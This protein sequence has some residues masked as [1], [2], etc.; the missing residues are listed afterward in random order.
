MTAT[1][2]VLGLQIDLEGDNAHP[3]RCTQCSTCYRRHREAARCC[4]AASEDLRSGTVRDFDAAWEA[5]QVA[6]Y[7]AEMDAHYAE[8]HYNC[9]CGECFTEIE[10][11]RQ[12]RKC[13]TYAEH[14]FCAEVT[15][16]DQDDKEVWVSRR[17]EGIRQQAAGQVFKDI[18][19]DFLLWDMA[20][21]AQKPLSYNPF[22]ALKV[23][24]PS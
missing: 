20:Q 12:C 11:A 5:E 19:A 14:G 7:L 16:R 15:D 2:T 24:G 17:R 18:A 4:E 22:A 3:F 10:Y 23:G 8:A 13:R 21:E 6:A 1:A 9:S